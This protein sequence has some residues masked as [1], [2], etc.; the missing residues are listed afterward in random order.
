MKDTETSTQS[1]I[2]HIEERIERHRK[3]FD[4]LDDPDERYHLSFSVGYDQKTLGYLYHDLEQERL[5]K[6][7]LKKKEYR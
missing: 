5:S 7:K 4:Q 3:L 6:I 1:L 2:N